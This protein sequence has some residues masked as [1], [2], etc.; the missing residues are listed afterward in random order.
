MIKLVPSTEQDVET[1]KMWAE[2]DIDPAHHSISPFWWVT[3]NGLLS[4]RIEDGK[5]VTMYVRLDSENGLMRN[6]TQFAP[7]P[8]GSKIRVVK[9]I[10]WTLPKMEPVGRQFGLTGF[11]YQSV[12]PALVSF[13]STKFG[14]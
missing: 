10:L 11:I 6:S 1:I 2:Q 14:F 7:E 5:G 9:S 8:E 4:Y 12:S 13:M 3:G